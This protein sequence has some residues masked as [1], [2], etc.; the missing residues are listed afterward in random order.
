M[1]RAKQMAAKSVGGKAPRKSLRMKVGQLGRKGV[2]K[3]WAVKAP[4]KTP[5][6]WKP[7]S[8][9]LL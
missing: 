9:L 8:G 7:G 4:S 5:H 1:A 3:P 2:Q 6:R